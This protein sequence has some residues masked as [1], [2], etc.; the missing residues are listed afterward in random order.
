MTVSVATAYLLLLAHPILPSPEPNMVEADDPL[1]SP[2]RVID[3]SMGHAGFGLAPGPLP[4]SAEG[5]IAIAGP[6][7]EIDQDVRSAGRGGLE[8][9]GVPHGRQLHVQ[10]IEPDRPPHAL[11][12]ASLDDRRRGE[13]DAHVPCESCTFGEHVRAGGDPVGCRLQGGKMPVQGQPG[14]LFG[15]GHVR[16]PTMAARATRTVAKAVPA[17]TIANMSVARA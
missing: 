14:A 3:V 15:D 11:P 16:V 6:H 7:A 9:N 4:T 13:D 17:A 1:Q 2:D 10:S 5:V 8:R 12:S